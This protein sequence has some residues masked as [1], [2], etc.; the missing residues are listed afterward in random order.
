M[1][2]TVPNTVA[3]AI[4]C[5]VSRVGKAHAEEAMKSPT[6]EVSMLSHRACK[7]MGLPQVG[8]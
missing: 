4:T 1:I 6:G 5:T 2:A 8:T 7:V 3:M